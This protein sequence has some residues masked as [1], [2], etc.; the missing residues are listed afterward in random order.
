METNL[1]DTEKKELANRVY[2]ELRAVRAWL[3]KPM[4]HVCPTCRAVARAKPAVPLICGY[5]YEPL[6]LEPHA[7]VLPPQDFR[8]A[9]PL[10]REAAPANRGETR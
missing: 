5:C 10:E 1:T 8:F 9:F 4:K 2:A 7:E 3:K 6:I